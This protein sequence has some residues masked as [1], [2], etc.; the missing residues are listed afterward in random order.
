MHARDVKQRDVIQ[1]NIKM[2]FTVPEEIASEFKNTVA[3]S[4]R[5][6]FVARAVS[7]KLQAINEERLTQ[8][9]I[10]SYIERYEED[11]LLN[12]EWEAATLEGWPP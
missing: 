9:L 10:E 5:S 6:D 1:V 12:E 3:K 8:E 2:T 11:R 7:E 4:K